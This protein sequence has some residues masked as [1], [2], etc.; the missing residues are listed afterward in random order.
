MKPRVVWDQ[1]IRRWRLNYGP[2]DGVKSLYF[3][4]WPS[5]VMASLAPDAQVHWSAS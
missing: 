3:Y 5:A 4:Y 1:S 2:A